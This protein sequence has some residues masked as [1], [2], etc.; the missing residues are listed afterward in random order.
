MRAMLRVLKI[1]SYPIAIYSGDPTFIRAEWASPSQFNHCIIA[2]KV[3]D[4]TKAPTVIEHAKLGRLL[5]FDA[6]DQFTGVGDLPD[7]LQ[8]SLALIMAGDDGG[9]SKMPVTPPD[10]DLLERKVE[11]NLTADGEINGKITERAGGQTSTVFRRELRALSATQYKQA[12]EGWLTRG[13]TGAK[14]VNVTSTDRQADAG[15][16]LNVEFS[17]PRYA[18]LMQNRLLVFKPVIVGRRNGVFLTETKRDQPVLLDSNSMKETSVFNLPPG[19]VV[20]ELPDAVKLETAFGRY[21]ADY[22]VKDGKLI[23]SRSLTT[24]R[25]TV[26][27]AKY[28]TVRDFYSK[29]MA[30]EQ[31]PV[32]LLKK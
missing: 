9:L 2:V 27:V 21:T 11:V 25:T 14:L 13:A 20:D 22:E 15:F 29:I 12:I 1:E 30:A 32:V 23:F 28:N 4:E 24:S 26:P 19:F 6:T 7:Y 8:G 31:S 10:T 5:I 18:Q 3:G 16:D 17:A